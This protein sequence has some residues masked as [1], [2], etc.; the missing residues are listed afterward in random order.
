MPRCDTCNGIIVKTD[1]KC[2]VCGQAIP[3]RR[4]LSLF[5][6]WSKPQVKPKTPVTRVLDGDNAS[7]VDPS[8]PHKHAVS[9]SVT[10]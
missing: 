3:G 6:W 4:K 5:R 7:G 9:L 2:Y 8:H 10:H 1:A